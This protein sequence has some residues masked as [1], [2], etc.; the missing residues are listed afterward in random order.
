MMKMKNNLNAWLIVLVGILAFGGCKKSDQVVNQSIEGTYVGSF[1]TSGTPKNAQIASVSNAKG[2]AVVN[3]INDKQIQVHCFGDAI[4]STF[5]LNMYQYGDSM[6]VC[7]DGNNFEKEYGHMMGMGSMMGGTSMMGN[8][9]TEWAQ[10]MNKEHKA[11]DVHFGGF[12]LSNQ[13]FGYTFRQKIG[14]SISYLKFQGN[15]Q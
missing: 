4:D 14:S 11:G 2:T 8:N 6:K 9:S 13:M 10:H 1:T 5:I 12:N 15:K 7:L 3:Q